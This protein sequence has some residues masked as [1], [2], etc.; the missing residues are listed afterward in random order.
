MVL[1]FGAVLI[2]MQ[3]PQ[4][5]DISYN[6]FMQ[7][8]ESRNI[9]S[10]EL[11]DIDATGTFRTPPNVPDRFDSEGNAIDKLDEEGKPKQFRKHFSVQLP[12]SDQARS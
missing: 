6:F 11:G 1:V 9:L 10:V 8:V 5:S 3:G 2:L 7:Q 12:N 4:R